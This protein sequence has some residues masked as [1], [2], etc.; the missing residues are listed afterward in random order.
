MGSKASTTTLALFLAFNLIFFTQVSA[1]P[2]PTCTAVLDLSVCLSLLGIPIID[3]GSQCC[4]C[5]N[6]LVDL[7]AA[8]CLCAYLKTRSL[9]TLDLT[10]A[11]TAIVNGCGKHYP[12]GYQCL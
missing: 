6:N 12:S 4:S 10:A 8:A 2:L 1:T 5:F 7:D 11:V 9:L 3:I